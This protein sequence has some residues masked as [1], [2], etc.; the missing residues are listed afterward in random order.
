MRDDPMREQA[1]VDRLY[2]ELR[3]RFHDDYGQDL[4]TWHEDWQRVIKEA[5]RTGHSKE[6]RALMQAER[7]AVLSLGLVN[8]TDVQCFWQPAIKAWV[9]HARAFGTHHPDI[10]AHSHRCL[11]QIGYSKLRSQA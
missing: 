7:A 8:A 5:I 10:D 11:V 3:E 4:N 2:S 9:A 6:G 1:D